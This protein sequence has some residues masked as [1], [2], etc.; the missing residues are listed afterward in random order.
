MAKAMTT[1]EI[2]DF[3]SAG[4]RTGK[5]ATVRADGSPHVVPIWF[6]LDGDDLL[7]NTGADTVKGRALAREGRAALCV[8]EEAA[9]YAYVTVRGPV[10]LST[11]LADVRAWATRI[12]ERYMGPDL[13]DSYGAR[14]GVEGELLVRLRLEKVS[15]FTAVA[16]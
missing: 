12:A 1:A 13:A 4:T 16:D 9:P 2:R 14:N 7:F 6:V 8:D 10:T 15:G 11:D 5:L 3:L